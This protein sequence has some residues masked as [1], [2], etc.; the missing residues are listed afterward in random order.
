[1]ANGCPHP[2][3]RRGTNGRVR[4]GFEICMNCGDVVAAVRRRVVKFD[5]HGDAVEVEEPRALELVE[6]GAPVD[7]HR[8]DDDMMLPAGASCSDCASFHR[9][10]WLISCDPASSRCDWSPS[11]FRPKPLPL[12]L[13]L[14]GRDG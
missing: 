14:G 8:P 2:E 5:R 3:H 6:R 4:R 10:A 7:V 9:C 1:M 13:P 12:A 11:R